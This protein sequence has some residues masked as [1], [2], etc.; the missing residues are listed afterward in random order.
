[1]CYMGRKMEFCIELIPELFYH[2]F[3]KHL[4]I[5]NKIFN[6]FF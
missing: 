1:M 3:Q 4:I 5:W 6:K 2:T